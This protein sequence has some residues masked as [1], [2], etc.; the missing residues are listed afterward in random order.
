M[1]VC[2]YVKYKGSSNL[3]WHFSP[4]VACVVHSAFID[5]EE[6]HLLLPLPSAIAASRDQL[7]ASFILGENFIELMFNFSTRFNAFQLTQSEVALFSAIMMIS[8][9]K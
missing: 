6:N 7:K 2:S 3:M 5:E 8:P 4:Q 1:S 9:G